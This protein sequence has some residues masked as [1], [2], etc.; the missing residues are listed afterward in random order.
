MPE[1]DGNG[2]RIRRRLF[3]AAKIAVSA[4]LMAWILSRA[5]LAAVM[6]ALAGVSPGWLV[7]AVVLQ[8]TGSV[9]VT[10]R[11][12]GL[13]AAR[14]TEAPFL[15]LYSSA[16]VAAF[17][18]QFLPS[19]I[20]GDAIRGYDAWRAGASP[21]AAALSLVVDRVLGLFALALFAI[22]AAAFATGAAGA[23]PG[24][25]LWIAAATLALCAAIAV[26]AGVLPPLSRDRAPRS[27]LAGKIA[28]KLLS[29]IDAL[30]AYRDARPALWR[31]IGLSVVVQGLVI[32]FYWTLG[33]ALGLGLPF[34]AYLSVV[35]IAIVVMM[36]P[37]T[38][39]GI[40]LREMIFVLLLGL[41]SVDEAAALAFAWLEFATFLA[42]GLFGGIVHA[43][44]PSGRIA[45]AEAMRGKMAGKMA[46]EAST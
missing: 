38:I 11:W 23:L 19:I 18:R 1:R 29:I 10:L 2:R 24:L 32:V 22:L 16:L 46:G 7:L 31:G 42:F 4:G 41:W 8:F 35:P 28:D 14:G 37:I 43:L 39:N 15:F 40:G 21:A 44:R 25:E 34:V 13:L 33:Q 30:A 9:L 20:G 5:D 36:A 45:P 3:L 27:G 26:L 12:R 6:D 17:Y